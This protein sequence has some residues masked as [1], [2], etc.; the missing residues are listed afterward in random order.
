M[1]TINLCS[2]VARWARI[3]TSDA[4]ME[5]PLLCLHIPLMLVSFKAIH[6]LDGTCIVDRTLENPPVPIVEE[7]MKSSRHA[8]SLSLCIE[9]P[10]P[11]VYVWQDLVL[12][13]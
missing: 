5:I 7:N 11:I 1:L 4:S 2:S 13:I 3:L 6:V 9:T 10:D 12:E 8:T